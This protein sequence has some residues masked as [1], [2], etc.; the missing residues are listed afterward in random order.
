MEFVLGYLK[1]ILWNFW[2]SY[3]KVDAYPVTQPTVEVR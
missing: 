3:L 2:S 1:V